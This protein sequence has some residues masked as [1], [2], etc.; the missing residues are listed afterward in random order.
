[1]DTYLQHFGVLGMKWGVRRYR[2]KDGTLTEEGKRRYLGDDGYLTKEGKKAFFKD[3]YGKLT[4]AGRK[5]YNADLNFQDDSEG[6]VAKAISSEKFDRNYWG[7]FTKGKRSNA[8]DSFSKELDLFSSE[9]LP[10]W[11]AKWSPDP[12]TG[13]MP[14]GYYTGLGKEWK[15]IYSEQLLNDFGNHPIKGEAWIKNALGYQYFD[16]AWEDESRARQ[17]T[18]K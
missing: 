9:F 2:N 17:D 14:K 3:D 18:K 5:V 10:R 8:A 12:K 4:N 6:K 15:R 16:W 7:G 11:N 1:M 13:M